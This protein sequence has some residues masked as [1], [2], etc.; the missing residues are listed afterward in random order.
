MKETRLKKIEDLFIKN[1]G[2]AT[3]SELLKIGT[4]S[5]LIKSLVTN[6]AIVKVK[7]GLYKWP[8][9]SGETNEDMVEL[10]HIIPNGVFCL[11]TALSYYDLTTYNSPEFNIAVYRDSKKPLLPNYPPVKIYYF[12]KKPYHTGLLNLNIEGHTIKIYDLEKTVC[13]CVRY[14]N[15]IGQDIMQETL[16]AYMTMK[17]RNLAKLM[18][19]AKILK[20]ETVIKPY[21]EALV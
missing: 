12:S 16:R 14:R 2:Y 9:Y 7:R 11:F 20:V 17:H 21:L 6:C 1:H 8:S 10:A 19:Y 4:D 18:E 5:R 13:D 3:T 15:K